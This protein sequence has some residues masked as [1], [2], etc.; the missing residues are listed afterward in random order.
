MT[1]LIFL[2]S[3]SGCFGEDTPD[4]IIPTLS[5]EEITMATRGQ[6]LTIDVDSNVAYSV[7][8]T[9]GLFFV[10]ADGV[11]RDATVMTIAAGQPLEILV[12][13]SERESVGLTFNNGGLDVSLNLTLEDSAEMML[14][15][16]LER[17]EDAAVDAVTPLL[18]GMTPGEPQSPARPG[19][20]APPLRGSPARAPP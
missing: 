15:F 13:D 6:L 10:D 14:L 4:E 12:L 8:R 17:D 11:F 19:T 18:L 1:I 20:S 5:I 16:Q 2:A 3:F 7:N 9:P